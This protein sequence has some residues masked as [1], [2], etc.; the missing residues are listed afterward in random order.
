[1]VMN[2][3]TFCIVF[4]SSVMRAS[5]CSVHCFFLFT[6]TLDTQK[7][8]AYL[9]LCGQQWQLHLWHEIS[10]RIWPTPPRDALPIKGARHR[11]VLS[12]LTSHWDTLF[13]MHHPPNTM[14]WLRE[15]LSIK[16]IFHTFY[17]K[18]GIW[19]HDSIDWTGWQT[20]LERASFRPLLL[21]RLEPF[22]FWCPVHIFLS[23]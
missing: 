16:S 5:F 21:W 13:I 18:I 10:Y 9:Y 11:V 23:L 7:H 15:N 3:F 17:S 2:H 20:K 22:F 1:M 14:S 4:M 19:L 6:K 12:S 8:P